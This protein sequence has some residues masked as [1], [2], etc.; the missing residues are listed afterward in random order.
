MCRRWDTPQTFCL[1]FIDELENQLLIK[2]PMKWAKKKCKNFN[3]NVAFFLKRKTQSEIYFTHVYLKA[4]WY[5]LSFLR[6]R[7]WQTKIDN[8][9]SVSALLT[10]T[11]FAAK[12]RKKQNFQK[13]K[14][15][16]EISFYTCVPKSTTIWGSVSE[17]EWERQIFLSFWAIFAL[18]PP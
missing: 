14:K 1:A 10:P 5:D 2:K 15:L 6:I 13:M 17:I 11:P 7:V 3:I 12:N 9:G 4:W 16:L 8:Y 18:L